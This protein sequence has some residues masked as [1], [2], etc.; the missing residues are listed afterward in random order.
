MEFGKWDKEKVKT[1]LQWEK[2]GYVPKD[3][4]EPE[5]VWVDR[6]GKPKTYYWHADNVEKVDDGKSEETL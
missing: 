5:Y 4:A 6:N 2:E 1:Q 3:G